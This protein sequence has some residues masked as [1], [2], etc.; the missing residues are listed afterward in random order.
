MRLAPI[1]AQRA[2]GR[3]TVEEPVP[4]TLGIRGAIHSIGENPILVTAERTGSRT[5]CQFFDVPPPIFASA[6][7]ERSLL[8]TRFYS[9]ALTTATPQAIFEAE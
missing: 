8:V 9:D 4:T 5:S 2:V 3:R 6:P 7:T 1:Q